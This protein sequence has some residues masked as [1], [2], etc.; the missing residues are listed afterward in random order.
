MSLK[1]KMLRGL[2]IIFFL[3]MLA[4]IFT[5]TYALDAYKQ[6]LIEN[7]LIKIVNNGSFYIN[8]Y[9]NI[10][11]LDFSGEN[12]ELHKDILAA[13]LSNALG[14]KVSLY[15]HE[16]KPDQAYE[17]FKKAENGATAFALLEKT[18]SLTVHLFFPIKTKDGY[19]IIVGYVRDY[20][21]LGNS[22][23]QLLKS[24][25]AVT[26]VIFLI[27]FLCSMIFLNH[28][29]KPLT[30]LTYDSRQIAQGNF[31]NLHE[32]KTDDEIGE[33]A[34]SFDIMTGK[35]QSQ[36]KILND[37]N[38]DLVELQKQKQTFLDNVTHELKTPLTIISAY[39]QVMEVNG[40]NDK[41]FFDKGV[42]L[43]LNESERLYRMVLDLLTLS[44]INTGP[45]ADMAE[46]DFSRLIEKTCKEMQTWAFKQEKTI[47]FDIKPDLVLRGNSEELKSAVMNI[48]DNAVKYGDS[49]S[50]IKIHAYRQEDKIYVVVD[51][52]GPEI[53][54]K[55]IS[56]LFQPFFRLDR[57]KASS[58]G[59]SGLG[60]TITKAIVEKHQGSIMIS[61]GAGITHVILE[62]PGNVYNLETIG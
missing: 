38:L 10:N 48:I 41:E 59:S 13:Q 30:A 26:I 56:E 29:I 52:N 50:T 25:V 49:Y 23:Q 51:N 43:I 19:N 40:F 45:D 7:D 12:M 24:F 16:Q 17:A 46:V 11:S 32:I 3:S 57:S 27:I 21:G 22:S 54:Q 62:F 60:L 15:S 2:L 42:K 53:P 44:S 20:T 47:D 37:R 14:G 35:I 31:A 39:A 36:L 4:S 61:S 33:L 5:I 1:N 34:R 8:Q 55:R 9:F 6:K 18:G 28:I 58:T